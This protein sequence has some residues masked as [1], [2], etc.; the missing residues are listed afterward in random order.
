MLCYTF[1]SKSMFSR[2]PCCVYYT[3]SQYMFSPRFLLVFLMPFYLTKI[4]WKNLASFWFRLVFF[5]WVGGVTVVSAGRRPPTR[6]SNTRASPACDAVNPYRLHRKH[7][8]HFGSPWFFLVGEGG[9]PPF[10]TAP[11]ETVVNPPPQPKGT[12]DN[13]S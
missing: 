12:T 8:F 2:V 3:L 13:Q 4:I 9:S 10:P 7:W 1:Q 5:G 6:S 11:S